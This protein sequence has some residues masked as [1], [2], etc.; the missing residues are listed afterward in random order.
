MPEKRLWGGTYNLVTTLACLDVTD[1]THFCGGAA[2][3]EDGTSS[4]KGGKEAVR[5]EGGLGR[6]LCV[7]STQKFPLLLA[8]ILKSSNVHK[9]ENIP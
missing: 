1:F 7:G 8:S 9:N 6:Q 4:R 2:G 3:V 5:K